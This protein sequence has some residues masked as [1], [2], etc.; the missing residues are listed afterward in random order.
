VRV[1]VDTNVVLRLHEPLHDII[2]I[3]SMP[4]LG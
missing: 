1:L 3:P 2:A 4:L